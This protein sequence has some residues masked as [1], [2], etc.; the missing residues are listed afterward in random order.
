MV[1]K[2]KK[3]PLISTLLYLVY[4]SVIVF[5]ALEVILRIYNPFPQRLKGEKI[6][7]ERNMKVIMKNDHI[8]V[9]EPEIHYSR[10]SLGFRGPE[11]PENLNNYCSI[12]AVGGST[13]ECYFVSDS[14]TW[15]FLLGAMLDSLEGNVWMNNAGLDGH[16]TYG[17]QILLEDYLLDLKP[18]K[19]LF[20][21]GC[22]DVERADLNAY[23]KRLVARG[24]RG[25]L[26]RS[27]IYILLQN[28]RRSMLATKMQVAH[29]Y[30]AF[31]EIEDD[32]LE[33]ARDS[34]ERILALQEPFLELYRKRLDTLIYTCLN[35]DIEPIL[36]TQPTLFGVGV[37]SISGLDLERIDL[38][39]N[40]NGK[41]W[42]ERLQLYNQ[43]TR[44]A[45]QD[46][47][48]RVIDL[49]TLLPRN[50]TYYYDALHFTV[51]GCRKVAE[52]LCNGMIADSMCVTAPLDMT[53]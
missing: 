28:I 8:E 5:I 14:L 36:I 12:V 23:D 2:K 3:H 34:I 24:L 13:T 6:V 42:W 33:I 46:A 15:P 53:P 4:L 19:I 38:K 52:I 51:P 39:K 47:G 43:V 27:E 48:I 31:H 37:D 32:T 29:Q 16:S 10:N 49:A 21:V 9:L 30:K 11:K 50:S 25:I 18:D 45:A 17:H 1:K 41:V 22:N 40:Y 7:L 20:L 44:Q 35:H 26:E